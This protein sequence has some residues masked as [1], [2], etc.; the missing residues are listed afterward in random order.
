MN[1]RHKKARP[2]G[3]GRK[4]TQRFSLHVEHNKT[5]PRGSGKRMRDKSDNRRGNNG[6]RG[7]RVTPGVPAIKISGILIDDRAS[8]E[9]MTKFFRGCYRIFSAGIAV[10]NEWGGGGIKFF[11]HVGAE[12]FRT[13]GAGEFRYSD[14]CE[15]PQNNSAAH[16][17]R[18]KGGLPPGFGTCLPPAPAGSGSVRLA[19]RS[20]RL[21]WSGHGVSPF[22][23]DGQ[24]IRV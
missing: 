20:W 8:R 11:S 14:A 21:A 6:C 15:G 1:D 10:R 22:I 9:T 16:G 13:W 19:L 18:P 17:T 3:S 2:R 4:H 5:R 24:S 7:R 23:P 12:F